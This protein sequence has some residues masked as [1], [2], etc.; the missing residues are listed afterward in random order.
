MHVLYCS[1]F[2]LL[3][4]V[5]DQC[6]F[7]NSTSDPFPACVFIFALSPRTA[8]QEGQ[9]LV[10]SS[11]PPPHILYTPHHTCLLHTPSLQSY[12]LLQYTSHHIS[13]NVVY[14]CPQPKLYWWVATLSYRKWNKNISDGFPRI[15]KFTE[16]NWREWKRKG[17]GEWV[18]VGTSF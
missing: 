11:H 5:L 1:N 16:K 8:G 17:V 3:Q 7:H 14:I 12:I 10:A 9:L 4:N 13:P 6:M 18:R 15:F 2:T